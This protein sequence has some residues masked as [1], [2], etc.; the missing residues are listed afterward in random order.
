MPESLTPRLPTD[1]T[2][3]AP[4]AKA[5][6]RAEAGAGVGAEAGAGVGA[7]ASLI[8]FSG[9][10]GT[11][12]STL[13]DATGRE[14]GI[15]VF[16]ADWLLGSLTP[17]GGYHLDGLL[18]I[19]VEMLTKLAHR[20]LRLGQSAILDHPAEDLAARFRWRTHA[21]AAGVKFRAVEC[22]CSDPE[23]HRAR[24]ERRARGIPGADQESARRGDR[25]PRW[26][27]DRASGV[28]D[29]WDHPAGKW[30]RAWPRARWTGCS[31]R[32]APPT[33]GT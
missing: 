25:G 28:L 3:R 11:G 19:S 18:D 7:G 31:P 5:D 16:A 12:E 10:P 2:G 24:L 6:A 26:R 14:L 21:E 29:A 15:P 30:R 4:L 20:Q 27:G 17:F 9:L 22:T 23:V 32:R 1:F 33:H 13:A 8:V